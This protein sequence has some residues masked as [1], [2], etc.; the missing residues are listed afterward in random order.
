MYALVWSSHDVYHFHPKL[1]LIFSRRDPD[2]TQTPE[3]DR[4]IFNEKPS[5]EDI[6]SATEATGILIINSIKIF[7]IFSFFIIP[8]SCLC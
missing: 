8:K 4:D 3:N 5:K 7:S 2:D 6:I 1:T